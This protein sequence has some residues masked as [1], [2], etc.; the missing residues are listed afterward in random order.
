MRFYNLPPGGNDHYNAPAD[1]R[2][3]PFNLLRTS[4]YPRRPA[5]VK[6]AAKEYLDKTPPP[7]AY[8]PQRMGFTR[9]KTPPYE[10]AWDA[11]VLS[12]LAA[13][14]AHVQTVQ[15]GYQAAMSRVPTTSPQQ[16]VAQLGADRLPQPSDNMDP[17]MDMPPVARNALPL[18]RVVSAGELSEYVRATKATIANANNARHERRERAM[19]AVSQQRGLV[20][21]LTSNRAQHPWFMQQG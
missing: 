15:G 13:M 8:L 9:W 5:L 18:D 2:R 19:A 20:D 6:Q 12:L 17:N 21:D 11:N 16:A 14:Q 7:V 3:L 4:L 10:V 1:I